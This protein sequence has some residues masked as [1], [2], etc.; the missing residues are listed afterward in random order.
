MDVLMKPW[1]WYIAGPLVGLIM[2]ALLILGRSFGFSSNFRTMCA[3]LGAGKRVEFFRFD[4]RSQSWNLLFLVGA[5]AGGF[6]AAHFLDNGEVPRISTATLGKLAS[7]GIETSVKDY[8]PKGI[9]N[10]LT[11]QNVLIWAFGGLLIGF[12]S[13]YAGGCTS[14][15]AIS[16]LSN[17]EMPSLIA[18]V[19]FFIGGLLMVHLVFPIIF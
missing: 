13:R 7:V 8:Y 2:L 18:V 1:P 5:V 4:W 14:G 6:V 15:H 19:G 12:G 16:G 10:S 11:V 3:A 9:F 17:L